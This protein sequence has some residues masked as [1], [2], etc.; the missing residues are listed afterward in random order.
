MQTLKTAAIVVLLLTVMYSGY[1]SLTTPPEPIDEE[2]TELIIEENLGFSTDPPDPAFAG[3]GFGSPMTAGASGNAG[4]KS[5]A[6]ASTFGDNQPNS[7]NYPASDT[8]SPSLGKSG[9]ELNQPV[10][11]GDGGP[12]MQ[13][14]PPTDAQSSFGN[15]FADIPQ[16]NAPGNSGQNSA[17]PQFGSEPQ[18]GTGAMA[19]SGRLPN[20]GAA[21]NVAAPASTEGYPS[22]SGTFD[23]PDPNQVASTFDPNRGT[24]FP[25]T[26]GTSQ[27]QTASPTGPQSFSLNDTGL[28]N[29]GLNDTAGNE[30]A[31]PG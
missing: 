27:N 8:Y 24:A 19:A 18:F 6:G 30:T 14:S 31:R 20:P 10:P 23:L 1:V 11:N 2:I 7:L 21:A 13:L 3:E 12:S 9:V 26:D 22:T 5:D 29:S 15:S 16:I 4:F 28:N 17:G 25:G